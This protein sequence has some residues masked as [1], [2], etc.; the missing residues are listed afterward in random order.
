MLPLALLGQQPDRIMMQLPA[1]GA[2]RVSPA[3]QSAPSILALR[4][5]F[6]PDSNLSTTGDGRFLME[7]ATPRCEGP[8]GTAFL[9]DPPP[10][11]AA[12]F[13]A[14]LQAIAHYYEQVSRGQLAINLAGSL[15]FPPEVDSALVVGP[16]ASYRPVNENETSD[17]L[18]VNL[19]AESLLAAHAHPAGVD[20]LAYDVVVVFHPGLGQDFTYPGPDPTP[21]DIPSTT[22]DLDMIEA[23]LG[24]RGIPLPPDN[25]LFDRPGILLPEGQNHIYYDIVEDIFP[26]VL[27]YCDLQI[28][29]TGTFALL[30]GFALDFPPLFDADDGET[31]VGVFGLMDVGSNNGQG[32]IPAPPTAW[33]RQHLGWEEPV[34]LSGE[35]VLGARHAAGAQTGRISLGSDEYFLVENRINWVPDLPGVDLDSLRFRN[36][37]VG[38][39]GSSSLPHYF[40]YLVDSAGLTVDTTGVITGVPNYDIGLPGSGLL[41]WHVDE[42]RYTSDMQGINND[43]TARAVALEEADGAVDIG[44][45]TSA[46]LADPTQGWRWDL[47]YASNEAFFVANPDRLVGNPQRLLALDRDTHP[48][49]HLNSGAR[50]G[51]ALAGIGPAAAEQFFS[52]IDEADVTRLPEGSKLAGF[53]GVDW[54]YVLGDSIYL[55]AMAVADKRATR[56]LIVSEHDAMGSSSGSAFWILDLGATSYAARRM[57]GDGI[58]TKTYADSLVARGGYFDDGILYIGLHKGEVPPA[59]DTTMLRY[60]TW[61]EPLGSPI[62]SWGRLTSRDKYT[63]LVQWPL[64]FMPTELDSVIYWTVTDFISLGDVDGDGLDEIIAGHMPSAGAG[65]QERLTAV[66]AVGTVLD[67]FP[68]AGLFAG[69]ALIANLMDDIRPELVVVRQAEIVIYSPEGRVLSRL[70]LRAAPDELFLMHMADGPVGLANG[71]RIHWFR[72]AEQNPHWVTPEGRHAR[73]RYSLNDGTV[74]AVQYEILDPARVYNYPNP[75]TGDRTTIRFYT[76]TASSA[77]IRIYTVDG[78]SVEKATL[79]P[80]VSNDYNEWVWEVGSNPAGLYYAVVELEEGAQRASALVKIAVV[81]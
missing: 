41:I 32:V 77:T 52:A 76:G 49:S 34:E 47:W 37:V 1:A 67:G 31:A 43:P 18:L 39:D 24:T 29:L 44:F 74:T 3:R 56:P 46:I 13:A 19:Y 48:S 58:L 65:E 59:T 23:A 63:A 22:V 27:D 26:G 25:D 30:L 14:Q 17:A 16:M 36:L 53:N 35:T 45:P 15:V 21:L 50:S 9:V 12:Y 40:D 10:H 62:T 68:I 71:D 7:I 55:G 4:V 75:V 70:G 57:S 51:I 66:N 69:P 8:P 60:F 61:V 6:T 79:R 33:T 20:L 5:A 78:L 11:D 42:S 38:T 2:G 72:P 80:L 64:P 73:S 54:V 81:R 28:G